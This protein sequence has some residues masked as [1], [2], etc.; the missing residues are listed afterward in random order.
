MNRL[1]AYPVLLLSFLV[2]LVAGCEDTEHS[3][4]AREAEPPAEAVIMPE[5]MPEDFAFSV[6][7]GITAKNEINT[8]EGT[9]TKD[10]IS[11]GSAAAKVRLTDAE[12]SEIYQ[13]MLEMNV[14]GGMEL[15]IA[16]KS[17]R[18]IPYDEEYWIIQVK[19]GQKALH[20][21]EEYCQTTPDAKKLKELRNTIVKLVQSKPE[22]QA[23][24]EAVGGYE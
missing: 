24:P 21:S 4:P 2:I 20:W 10:L 5:Q 7:Y 12:T 19:G 22:Y 14:L 3:A 9:V 23:L 16:D 11:N 15:E 1:L 17:C 6:R 13:Q 8:F 18:Q